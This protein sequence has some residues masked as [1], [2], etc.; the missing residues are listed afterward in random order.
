MVITESDLV[1][2]L[3]NWIRG[4][5]EKLSEAHDS[6][7]D[8]IDTRDSVLFLAGSFCGTLQAFKVPPPRAQQ[9]TA[10]FLEAMQEHCAGLY[11]AVAPIAFSSNLL[12]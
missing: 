10:Q 12:N 5:R 2:T 8:V 11:P 6:G 4:A 3:D 9:L 7:A 1:A